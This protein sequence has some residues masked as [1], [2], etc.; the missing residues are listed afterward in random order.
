MRPK[1]RIIAVLI[2]STRAFAAAP[3]QQGKASADN[4]MHL[5]PT[6]MVTMVVANVD[7]EVDWYVNVLGF[8]ELE[9]PGSATPAPN[10]SVRVRK[11]ELANF[12]LHLVQ[13]RGSTRPPVKVAYSNEL[14]GYHHI[15][16]QTPS[17]DESYKWLTTHG[18]TNIDLSRDEKTNALR[19][20]KFHDPEGN[21]IHVE[22][23]F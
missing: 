6:N 3:G 11:I 2:L 18:V 13:Q 14:E 21:E 15:S 23:P 12:R 19:T 5:I 10:A 22:R 17:I 20:M 8:H 16:F 1:L 4:P 9:E 7:R